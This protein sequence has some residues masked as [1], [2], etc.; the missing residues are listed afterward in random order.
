[1]TIYFAMRTTYGKRD[2]AKE[3]TMFCD[4]E[5]VD[6]RCNLWVLKVQTQKSYISVCSFNAHR[7]FFFK[8][9]FYI[10][11]TRMRSQ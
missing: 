9:F 7:P 10:L 4:S 8:F 6:G 5:V 2:Y 11:S 3:T 1:M